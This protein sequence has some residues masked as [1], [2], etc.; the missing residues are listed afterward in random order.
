MDD[1]AASV[2][3]IVARGKEDTDDR[4]H[5]YRAGTI[6]WPL[7]AAE[8]Q[9][10]A[11]EVL[12]P[13]F[14]DYVAGVEGVRRNVQGNEAAFE[15][16]RLL[17]RMLTGNADRDLSV[18]LF[19][20]T[21]PAP[22]LLAPIG[23]LELAH[24][25]G[26]RAVARAAAAMGIPFVM[27]T[28]SSNSMEA[29]ASEMGTASRWFQLYWVDDRD[30]VASLLDR[31]SRA[32]YTAVVAT[33]DTLHSNG[34]SRV[35]T[36]YPSFLD[37]A[38]IGQFA[39][40][41]VFRSRLTTPPEVDPRVAGRALTEVFANPRLT[42]PDLLWLR[43]HTDLPLLVKGVLRPEDALRTREYGIDGIVVSNH[44]GYALDSAVAPLDALIGVRAALGD[45]ATILM[46]GGIRRGSDVVKALAL[47][48]SAVLIGRPYLFGLAVA[49]S[50]GVERVLGFLTTELDSTLALVGGASV[51]E[52]DRSVIVERP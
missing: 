49:G 2:T 1:D 38:G 27:S 9:M 23:I 45:G 13:P 4:G 14:F 11:A 39:S 31:A 25:D 42:W 17:P 52:L 48:A 24:P 43:E 40:D 46:D 33:L 19:G 10:R 3:D 15:R 29:I 36:V 6:A 7:G 26:E 44:G 18:E 12:P 41:P 51:T 34:T 5:R 16:W 35:R 20:A 32:G 37:G 30:V 8:W 50:S 22:F 47:G 28:V 21:F